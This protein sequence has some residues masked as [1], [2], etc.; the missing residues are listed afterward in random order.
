MFACKD[1]GTAGDF[2]GNEAPNCKV[3]TCTKDQQ[4]SANESGEYCCATSCDPNRLE[5]VP[6]L[7]GFLCPSES[8][9]QCLPGNGN[10]IG[11]CIEPCEVR[12]TLDSSGG[13]PTRP[14]CRISD[15]N[16]STCG[17]EE[18]P[19]CNKP[20]METC[21]YTGECVCTQDKSTECFAVGRIWDRG[22]CQCKE[23]PRGGY[24]QAVGAFSYEMYKKRYYSPELFKEEPGSGGSGSGGRSGGRYMPGGPTGDNSGGDDLLSKYGF[25]LK[26]CGLAYR[27]EDKPP[28]ACVQDKLVAC[29]DGRI[30]G[31]GGD[32]QQPCSNPLDRSQEPKREYCPCI[33]AACCS[34]PRQWDPIAEE[35][36]CPQDALTVVGRPICPEEADQSGNVLP[37]TASRLNPN[38]CWCEVGGLGREAPRCEGEGVILDSKSCQC[39]KSNQGGT[40][41]DGIRS[42]NQF[43]CRLECFG[44]DQSFN[45]LCKGLGSSANLTTCKCDGEQR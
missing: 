18:C 42:F 12:E 39:V 36:V 28:F 44:N 31:Q 13:S 34:A 6:K 1:T 30:A 14:P 5:W 17:K 33:G 43:T 37:G 35:C 19:D 2:E 11:L 20:N 15:P 23:I 32:C 21:P 29:P 26:S 3:A 25:V 8:T 10:K 7:K 16:C 9:D 27:R 22:T 40:Q 41:S 24:I 45:Q 4:N 38:S